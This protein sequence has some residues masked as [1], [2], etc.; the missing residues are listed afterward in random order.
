MVLRFSFLSLH[1]GSVSLPKWPWE[2]KGKE[3]ERIKRE[4]KIRKYHLTSTSET[5]VVLCF[6]LFSV[7]LATYFRIKLGYS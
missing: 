4:K 7:E 5:N 6:T 3:E 2:S 1:A